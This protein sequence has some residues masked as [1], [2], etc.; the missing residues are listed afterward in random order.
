VSHTVRTCSNGRQRA[1]YGLGW[2]SRRNWLLYISEVV[3]SSAS[4]AISVLLHTSRQCLNS[5]SLS[6]NEA[7]TVPLS[8]SAMAKVFHAESVC[9]LMAAVEVWCP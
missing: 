1:T 9:N 5:G 2:D 4:E 3:V 6:P 8:N 7:C